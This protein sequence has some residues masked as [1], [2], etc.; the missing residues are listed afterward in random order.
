MLHS[1]M[2]VSRVFALATNTQQMLTNRRQTTHSTSMAYTAA[3]MLCGHVAQ[4]CV[5]ACIRSALRWVAREMPSGGMFDGLEGTSPRRNSGFD[6]GCG[7]HAFC[8]LFRWCLW[9]KIIQ[10]WYIHIGIHCSD[11]DQ[12]Q[13]YNQDPL[14][15]IPCF[16]CTRSH[17]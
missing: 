9:C 1:A 14:S 13:P 3:E 2:R 12:V 10:Q 4:S 17:G 15:D 7:Y 8:G 16:V 11:V 6:N 5:S